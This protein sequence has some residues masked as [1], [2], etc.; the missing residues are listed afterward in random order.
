MLFLAVREAL[1]KNALGR[2]ATT[3][4]PASFRQMKKAKDFSPRKEVCF[5]FGF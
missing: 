3:Q 5:G 1:P 2:C 4:E